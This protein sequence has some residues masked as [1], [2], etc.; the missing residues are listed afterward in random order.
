M[1]QQKEIN[2]TPLINAARNRQALDSVSVQII[3]S[4][5]NGSLI[6]AANFTNSVTGVDY[7]IPLRDSGMTRNSAGGYPVRLDECYSDSFYDGYLDPFNLYSCLCG[8]RH[9]ILYK[10]Y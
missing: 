7:D 4:G 6:G 3:N 2:L 1:S 5:R 10:K 9:N 8:N